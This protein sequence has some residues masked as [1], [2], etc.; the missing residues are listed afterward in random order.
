[1]TTK[2]LHYLSGLILTLFIG[3]HLFNHSLSIFGA[4]RHIEVMDTLR[5]FYRNVVTETV[6]LLAVFVQIVSGI[7]LF[8]AKRKIASS[9]FEKLQLWSGLYLA[10]FLIIHLSAV[11]AGRLLLHLD[12]NFYFGVAGLNTFPFSLFFI[13]YY[14]LAIVSLF[15]HIAAIHHQKMRRTVFSLSP[16]KQAL[17]IFVFGVLLTGF[18]FYGLTNRFS[19]YAIPKAYDVII[20]K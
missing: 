7:K 13:P 16:N 8:R 12:T 14:A 20:G 3:L 5:F 1:M 9:K 17:A 6:L 10:F 2:K 19:G 4:S 15:A 18:I 11:F